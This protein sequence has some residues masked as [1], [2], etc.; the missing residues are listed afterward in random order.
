MESFVIFNKSNTSIYAAEAFGV[1]PQ[2]EN[3]VNFY[4][5]ETFVDSLINY[6]CTIQDKLSDISSKA[7]I[8]QKIDSM[9][10]NG[11]LIKADFSNMVFY[12]NIIFLLDVN[13]RGIF[14]GQSETGNSINTIVNNIMRRIQEELEKNGIINSSVTFDYESKEGIA[15]KYSLY[16]K[17]K[18]SDTSREFEY[19]LDISNN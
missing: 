16:V 1:V 6:N 13:F 5:G 10:I 4:N 18:D 15:G 3:A 14:N 17:I 8:R 2:N 9:M 19:S 7:D 11:T 12:S